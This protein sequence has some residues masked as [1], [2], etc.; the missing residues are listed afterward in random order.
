MNA[1]LQN[2]PLY[3]FSFIKF[4]ERT[5]FNLILSF[6]AGALAAF[7]MPPT[8]FWFTLFISLP[9]LHCAVLSAKNKKVAFFAGWLFGFGYFVISLSWIANALLVDGNPYLWAW[10][11][12]AAGLPAL[13]SFFPA[14][15]CLVT[16]RFMRLDRLSGWFGFIGALALSE[17]LRGNIFTG[18]P[19][20]LFGYT[21]V[22]HLPMI[23]SLYLSDVYML[24]LLTMLWAFAPALL[25]LKSKSQ[26]FMGVAIVL[27]T[28]LGNLAYGYA[29]L[30]TAPSPATSDL[31]IRVVQPNIPQSEKWE[32]SKTFGHFVRHLQLSKQAP[33]PDG[34][35]IVV[36]P[37]TAVS[38]SLLQTP[39]AQIAMR[40]MLARLP[41]GS[42]LLTGYLR[43][44]EEQGAYFNSLVEIDRSGAIKNVY[45]KHHLVPFGEYI[46]F[47]QWIPLKPIVQFQGFGRGDGPQTLE[48]QQGIKFSPLVCYEIIF[49]GKS[50]KN[51][52]SADFIVNVTNDA[53]YGKSAG[54]YQHL[55]ISLYRAVEN[56][57]PVIRS[58][59]TGFSAVIDPYGKTSLSDALFTEDV[60][61]A[62]M[63]PKRKDFLM[64]HLFK[65][66]IFLIL[67]LSF[68]GFALIGKYF[69]TNED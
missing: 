60:I 36:W 13:L 49:P 11:L 61:N 45:D 14:L 44:D 68:F 25:L 43:R 33:A 15:A 59:N 24:T 55:A 1:P 47:Q 12:A 8:G 56:G 23:Q 37:E 7:A 30:N 21:W 46:P 69:N 34:P 19:W 66:G 2:E 32:R 54:P 63:P 52:S 6:A 57:I 39:P 48:S 4:F 50:V 5:S 16:K 29:S 20:N 62:K 18:F 53:W 64:P 31:N 3:T 67:A 22:D 9:A 58:A 38:F 65:N 17:W 40:D 42:S 41:V 27:F 28:L 10:P 35:V 51:S 26:R